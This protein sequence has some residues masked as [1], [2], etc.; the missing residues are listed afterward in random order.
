[1]LQQASI[2]RVINHLLDSRN[3]AIVNSAV[4]KN[5]LTLI[6]FSGMAFT[7]KSNDTS[8][9]LAAILQDGSGNAID[10]TAATVK[11]HMKRIGASSAT[12]DADATIVS[13]DAGSVKYVWSGTD[14]SAAG[15]YQAEFEVTYTNG[16]IETFPNDSTIAVEIIQDLA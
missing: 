13:A 14:T 8:P 16:A 15:T 12:V 4:S 3:I 6:G 9:Q 11:F 2:P 5:S 10:L 7:I 1:M